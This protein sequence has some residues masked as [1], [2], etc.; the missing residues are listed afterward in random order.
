ML[1][2]ET[3]NKAQQLEKFEIN[4]FWQARQIRDIREIRGFKLNLRTLET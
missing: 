1:T 2:N 4:T 3:N